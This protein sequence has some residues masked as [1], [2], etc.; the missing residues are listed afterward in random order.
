MEYYRVGCDVSVDG[1]AVGDIAAIY[2]GEIVFLLSS[3]DVVGT[4]D[5]DTDGFIVGDI[6]G[7]A[8][9]IVG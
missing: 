5:G 1:F 8:G 2:V 9:D 3:G 6:E 4:F 7:C